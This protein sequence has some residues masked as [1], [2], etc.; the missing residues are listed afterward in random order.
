MMLPLPLLALFLAHFIPSIAST[1]TPAVSS[2]LFISPT[3]GFYPNIEVLRTTSPASLDLTLLEEA[4]RVTE[5][6]E[7]LNNVA[8]GVSALAT[9]VEH[10]LEEAVEFA[11][12]GEEALYQCD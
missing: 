9:V 12:G 2:C 5:A 8:S 3:I 4:N 6:G 1:I 10:G 11:L 7:P